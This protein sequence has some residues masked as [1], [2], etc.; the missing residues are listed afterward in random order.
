MNG[1]LTLY[2]VSAYYASFAFFALLAFGLNCFCLLVGWMPGI[3]GC[4]RFFQR[5]VHR[6]FALFVW[7]VSFARIVPVRYEG[8][9]RWPRRNGL[10]IV[11]NHPG[12]MDV[13][14]LLARVPEA[15]C[16]YKPDVGHNPLFGATARCAG[17]LPS[18]R[19]YHLLRTAATKLAA[20]YNLLVFPE[21]TRSRGNNLNPLK[22]G[23]VVMAREAQVPIQLVRIACDSELL[24]K[25]R[26]WWRVPRLPA[27]VTVTLG[28]CLPP[29]TADTGA[30]VKEIEAWFNGLPAEEIRPSPSPTA[31]ARVHVGT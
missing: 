27:T 13:G 3:A 24:T 17:Y 19:G 28:P 26:P 18:N 7:W 5:L 6:E 30:A 23:F 21:G 11:A 29:P 22:P 15:M 14:W 10:V 25:A 1:L 31:A 8:F 12:L 16:I 4:E 20:G 2:Q 9:A